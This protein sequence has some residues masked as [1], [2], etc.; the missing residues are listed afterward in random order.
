MLVQSNEKDPMW[1]SS[2]NLFAGMMR[3]NSNDENMNSQYS[4]QTTV[5]T[6]GEQ[7]SSSVS[8]STSSGL[9]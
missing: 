4:D 1:K 8:K 9:Q 6:N 3:K 2:D 5:L 7:T